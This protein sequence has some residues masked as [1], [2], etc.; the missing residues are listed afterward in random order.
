M[1]Q[2]VLVA[3]T[4]F[5]LFIVLSLILSPVNVA[6]L[7]MGGAVAI[8]SIQALAVYTIYMRYRRQEDQVAF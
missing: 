7:S 4:T 2:F 1:N 5:N 3:I 6:W 8:A